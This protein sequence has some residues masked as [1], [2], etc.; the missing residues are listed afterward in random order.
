MLEFPNIN[1]I[2]LELGPIIIRWYSLA[3]IAG[4]VGG[5]LLIG[6]MNKQTQ[7][8]NKK[9]YD[10]LMSY[11]ILGIILGGRL[12][13]VLFYNAPYFIN[14]PS[15]ILMVWQ[16]GMSFHGG[17]LGVIFA[18]WLFSYIHKI[19]F[20][21][22]MDMVAA[23]VP[24]GLFFGRCANFINGE[25]YG[26]V[27]NSPLGMVFPDGGPQLRYPSQLFEAGLEGIVL[28]CILTYLFWVKK[29]WKM[30]GLISGV[31]LL[32]YAASRIF[33]EQFREPDPQ[34]GFF[35]GNI[36]MGQILS[37]PMIL[38]GLYLI[39]NAARKNNR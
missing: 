39:F 8:L 9:Q 14:H 18:I 6:Q 32:F 24:I 35:F 38:L 23:V 29:S 34:L 7:L 27:T 5:W 37:I 22:I 12:G 13:Y 3:Y 2:A 28:F 20:F 30:P 31:F 19:K 21:S 17:M 36:T 26:R 1:P 15:E 10:S 33:I 4:I 25:L 16:G 11:G